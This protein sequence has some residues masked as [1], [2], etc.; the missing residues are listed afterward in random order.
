[1][2]WLANTYGIDLI[3]A[4]PQQAR[5]LAELQEK[6]TRYP[7]AALRTIRIGGALLSREGIERVKAYLCRNIV[8]MYSSTEAGL[9]AVAPHD[10]IASVPN[11]VGFIIPEADVQI[12]DAEGTP[13]AS[14][15]EG[16]VR[17]RTRQFLENFNI[18]DQDTWYY[19]GDTGWVTK[20]GVLCIAGR[21]GDVIN[22]GGVK[23]S[24]A[25]FEDFLRTCPGV[26]DA[27][28]CTVTETQGYEE[29]WIGLVLEAGADLGLLREKIEANGHF[30]TN[31][32][33]IFVI[34]AIPRGALGKVKREELKAVLSRNRG[35]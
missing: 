27:G 3:I 28:L 35:E 23:L 18:E 16:I 2:L 14:G 19:P 33:R 20:D 10:M 6:V 9:A 4:S 12:V 32:D 15:K 1:M 21:K 31:F 34:D 25:D 22:R 24:T 29:A 11:A 17:L 13:L 26:V 30:G 7:L 8:I 5:E